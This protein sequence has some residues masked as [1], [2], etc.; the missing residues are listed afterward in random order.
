MVYWAQ[1]Q[2]NNFISSFPYQMES[3]RYVVST[4]GTVTISF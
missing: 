4:V 2:F 1:E 3:M